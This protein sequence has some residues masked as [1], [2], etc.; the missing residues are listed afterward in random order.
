MTYI[1]EIAREE[2]K[3][4]ITP[5]RSRI[6]SDQKNAYTKVTIAVRKSRLVTH[7]E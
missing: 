5:R 3:H 7:Q 4:K 1:V 6:S 2:E